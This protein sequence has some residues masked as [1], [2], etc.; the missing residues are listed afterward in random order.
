L[1]AAQGGQRHVLDSSFPF[2]LIYTFLVLHPPTSY[3]GAKN[4]I[5]GQIAD[6]LL[7]KASSTTHFYDLC[8][9]SG[10]ITVELLNRGVA[11]DRITMCDAGPWGLFWGEIGDG[12]FDIALLRAMI[13]KLPKDLSEIKLYMQSLAKQPASIATSQTF[14]LLQ[15]SSFGSKPIWI[16]G[17]SWK[18]CSFRSYWMPTATSNRRSPVN[19]MMPLPTTLLARVEGLC[20]AGKGITG[21]H[22]DVRQINP[23]SDSIVYVDPPYQGT[24]PYGH[25]LDVV[26]LA[27]TIGRPCYVSEGKPLNEAAIRLATEETRKKGGI[28]G[29][30]KIRSNEE[31]LS[32]F[33]KP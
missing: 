5:A 30:K 27:T 32:L 25:N 14:L 24:T 9:G 7:A 2:N 31:W 4:R 6:L 3:Q 21:I 8:C 12:T 17:D 26:S 10:A 13:E 22:G 33:E 11:P 16:E 29:A 1:A 15:A 19:P 20:L 18:N 23:I 28:S